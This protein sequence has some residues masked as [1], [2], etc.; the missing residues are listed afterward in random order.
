MP[1]DDDGKEIM[2]TTVALP[3]LCLSCEK[4][5]DPDE[6]ILCNLNRLSQKDDGDFQCRAYQSI[7]GVLDED[8]IE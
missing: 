6:E 8:T 5:D 2:P 3:K 7:Y 4:L 1:F